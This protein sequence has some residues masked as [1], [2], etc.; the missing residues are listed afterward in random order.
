M[1]SRRHSVPARALCHHNAYPRTRHHADAR[2][3]P[4]PRHQG[5]ATVTFAN[6]VLTGTAAPEAAP[7]RRVVS[8]EWP[9]PVRLRAIGPLRPLVEG[10]TLP[11]AAALGR[12]R[13]GSIWP[14]AR[15]VRAVLL[16]AVAP[17][18]AAQTSGP[19]SRSRPRWRCGSVRP[20]FGCGSQTAQPPRVSLTSTPAPRS[21]PRPAL[22]RVAMTGN[23]R[24]G[25]DARLC[26]PADPRSRVRRY[27]PIK[28]LAGEMFLSPASGR[29]SSPAPR[30]AV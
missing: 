1:G 29:P 30:T 11:L 15:F 7:D 12:A 13:L 28:K 9:G 20:W 17:P 3:R 2:Q 4:G 8:M 23:F 24:L 5:A 21:G 27:L 19:W 18:V 10:E 6:R 14:L 22:C 26:G 25:R 16:L